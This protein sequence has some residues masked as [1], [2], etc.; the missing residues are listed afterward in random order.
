MGL[1]GKIFGN[2][3]GQPDFTALQCDIHSHLIPGIDDG[4]KDLEMSREMVEAM[5]AAGFKR[6]ITTPHVMSDAYRNKRDGIIAGCDKLNEW[7]SSN[8]IDFEVTPS[9][10]Y[11]VDEAFEAMIGKEELLSFGGDKKYV[12]FETSYVNQPLSFDSVIFDLQAAGYQP[13][14][15]H[16]ERY[17]YLWKEELLK[18]QQMK[19]KGLLFQ[20]NIG[21]FSGAYDIRARKIATML[22]KA[23]MIDFLGTDMHRPV[24]TRSWEKAWEKSAELRD[25]AGSERLL[26][27]GL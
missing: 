2:A 11:Y 12:L 3:A 21:S 9:A 6:A 23:D 13:V 8:E 1:F 19:E 26:N 15:A 24:Q 5:M 25:L 4:S 20:V 16:P 22:A 27:S 10:E 17:G 14:L 18:F 7:L